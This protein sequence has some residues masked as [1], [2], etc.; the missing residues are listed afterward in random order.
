MPERLHP[1]I[2]SSGSWLVWAVL[3][4]AFSVLLLIEVE[5]RQMGQ[6]R[7]DLWRAIPH[8]IGSGFRS[9]LRG[10][11]APLHMAPWQA[12]WRAYRD[13]ARRW[14]SPLAAWVNT[15]ERIAFGPAPSSSRDGERNG[16]VA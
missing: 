7:R 10:Y 5:H 6:R 2:I 11:F 13:P 12:A 1:F 15:I 16:P 14:W 9:G 4:L 3:V 8:A